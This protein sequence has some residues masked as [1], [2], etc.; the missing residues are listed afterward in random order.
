MKI[1]LKHKR[2]SSP[3]HLRR[4]SHTKIANSLSKA[5]KFITEQNHPCL[6]AQAVVK[7]E[8]LMIGN[9]SSLGTE[10]ATRALGKAL[11]NFIDHPDKDDHKLRSYMAVFEST[12]ELSEVAFE[13]LLWKQLNLLHE[14]DSQ[15][16]DDTVSADP[17]DAEFSFS[18]GGT[19]FYIIGM[20]PNSSR[21]ARQFPSN[22]LVFNLH[23]QFQQIKAQ[24][25]YDK[26]RNTIRSRD[27]KLQGYVNPMVQDHGLS[28]EAKQYSGREVDHSWKCPFSNKHQ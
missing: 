6:A 20:H 18:F 25:K 19:A 11:C 10:D 15:P 17:E 9:F 8:A 26:M 13:Q 23:S 5:Q 12:V 14:L 4:P 1:T 21:Q 2:D 16:W 3:N 24:G 22:A 28:S 7:R 27:E